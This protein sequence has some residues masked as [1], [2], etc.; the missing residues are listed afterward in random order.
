MSASQT[1]DPALAFPHAQAHPKSLPSFPG[2][3]P[4]NSH[5]Q[6]ASLAHYCTL[7]NTQLRQSEFPVLCCL[8]GVDAEVG[9][10]GFENLGGTAAAEL[11]RG[12]SAQL[13][14][15]GGDGFAVV[16]CVECSDL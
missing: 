8:A 13:D 5:L 3:N 9:L 12:G 7:P 1:E 14:K 4:H 6:S 15:V 16:H 2:S 11:A 10:D